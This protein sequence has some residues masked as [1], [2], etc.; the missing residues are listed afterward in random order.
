MATFFFGA[1]SQHQPFLRDLCWC[2][3]SWVGELGWYEG[4]VEIE[5][6]GSWT[7]V[8]FP[9]SVRFDPDFPS[10]REYPT[11]V[12]FEIPADR[13]RSALLFGGVLILL[14]LGGGLLYRS[15]PR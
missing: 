3:T 11:P 7:V 14:T 6:A 5:E 15:R 1:A 8:P 12:G 4:R 13:D 10:H 2:P 9:T